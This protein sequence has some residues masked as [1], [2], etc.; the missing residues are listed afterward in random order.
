MFGETPNNTRRD[1]CAPRDVSDSNSLF[2][3]AHE[4]GGGRFMLF[5]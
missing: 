5:P 4:K 1:A 3:Q 2:Y